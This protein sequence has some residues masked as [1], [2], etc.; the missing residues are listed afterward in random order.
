M[1]SFFVSKTFFSLIAIFLFISIFFSVTSWDTLLA[2]NDKDKT[3]PVI[4]DLRAES[5]TLNSVVIMWTTDEPADS[6]IRYGI[7]PLINHNG[8]F[9]PELVFS[10]AISLSELIPATTYAFCVRSKDE[11]NNKA[12]ACDTFITLAEAPLPAPS[13]GS[14]RRAEEPNSVSVSGFAYP[15]AKVIVSF[16]SLPFKHE[17][18]KETTANVDGSFSVSFSSFL[19]GFYMF[20]IYGVDENGVSSVR[21]GLR[22]D[23]VSGIG[24][25]T[26]KDKVLL[27]P[28]IALARDVV[29]WGDNI[30]VSGST[31]PNVGVLVDAGDAS[32]ETRSDDS[33][34]YEITIN[35]ARFMPGKISIRARSSLI[36]K[37][38]YDYSL[39]KIVTI[40]FTTVP[41]ADL[42]QD[43]AINI[44]DLSIYLAKPVD[45]NSDG[46]VNITDTSIFLRAFTR[47]YNSQ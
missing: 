8:P 33:G 45:M 7:D 25:K 12:D 9:D 28:T 31:V 30:V 38:G 39:S 29:G 42:N 27:P 3:P 32:F 34:F 35:T 21:K 24:L 11:R 15:N 13:G 6:D 18:E 10:H 16:R 43:G 46:Q 44:K 23:F 40:S 2:A 22:F 19:P 47:T 26:F 1:K 5:V 4:S 36:S 37:L 20:S 17:F 41:K 14:G